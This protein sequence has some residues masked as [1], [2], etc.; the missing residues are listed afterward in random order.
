VVLG[1]DNI[2]FLSILVDALPKEKQKQARLIG[3]GLALGARLLLLL[4]IRWVMK[5]ETPL[6][7][8][9][10]IG[11]VPDIWIKNHHVDAV[12]GRDIVLL[13]GGLFL[14]AKSVLEIHKKTMGDEEHEVKERAARASFAGILIQIIVLD[15]VFSLDSVISAIG[16][17]D[18]I[19]IMVVAMLVAVAFMAAFAGRVSAFIDK[20]PTF[21]MLALSFLVLIGIVLLADGLGAPISK[22]Y[23]YTAM[24][25]ALGVELLNMRVRRKKDRAAAERRS[26]TSLRPPA[27]GPGSG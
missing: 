1:I 4:T 11:W 6:F 14:I 7:H 21:K 25:F 27:P 16:M 20:N 22:G 13:L 18:E 19:W 8:W 10:W 12:T 15:I 5:L 17:V 3:L 24:V 2:I 23:V 9:S 26:L